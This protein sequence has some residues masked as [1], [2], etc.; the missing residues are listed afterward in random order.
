[1]TSSLSVADYKT[2]FLHNIISHS[3]QHEIKHPTSDTQGDYC[4]KKKKKIEE[5]STLFF[6]LFWIGV[7]L[8]CEQ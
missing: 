3:I 7:I 1:M 8:I 2:H 6:N 4:S 5:T